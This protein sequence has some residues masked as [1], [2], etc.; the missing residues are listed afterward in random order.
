[1]FTRNFW[2]DAFERAISTFAQALLGILG[3][4]AIVDL[5]GVNWEEV[6]LAS[7]IA[8]AT[9]IL[10]SIVASKAPFGDDSASLVELK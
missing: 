4:V 10:K 8:A 1:M 9:S 6:F 3:A 2:K 7:G 5:P